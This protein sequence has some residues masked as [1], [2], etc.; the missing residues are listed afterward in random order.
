MKIKELYIENFGKLSKLKTSFSDGINSFVEDNGFG[1][2]TLSV[3]IKAMLYGFD[4]TRRHS[5]DEN[6]RKKYNPWQGGAFG[7]YLIFETNGTVYRVERTFGAKASDD[8]YNLYNLNTGRESEDFGES[9]GEELFGIDAE[10]FERT[11]FLS[12]KNL[13]GKNT[14]QTISAK[15]SNLVGTEGDIGGFDEAIKLLDERRKF[16]QKRGGAGEIQDVETEISELEDKIK[17]L[18]AKRSSTLRS[19]TEI[20]ALNEKISALRA[21]KGSIVEKERREK[22][23]KEK[24]GYEIQYREM[25]GALTVDEERERELLS[26]FS[27]KIPTNA[28]LALAADSASE[29][30]RLER[31]LSDIGENTELE[32]LKEFFAP[33][34]TEEECEKMKNAARRVGE[35]RAA[36]LSRPEDKIE[37]APFK[38]TPT[39]KEVE[40]RIASIETPA[41]KRSAVNSAVVLIGV[42][43]TLLGIL[44]GLLISIPL[45]SLSALGILLIFV[46]IM[47]TFSHNS[48]KFSTQSSKDTSEFIYE[49]FGERI[50]FESQ[51]SALYE[52]KS[53]L[54]RYETQKQSELLIKAERESLS[55]SILSLEREVREFCERFPAADGLT[56]EEKTDIISRKRRRFDMLLEY[57]SEKES[58]RSML[59]EK[60]KNHKERLESFLTLFPTRTDDPISEIRKNLA[61]YEVIRSSLARRRGDAER[62]ASSHGINPNGNFNAYTVFDNTNDFSKELS[63]LEEELLFCEREKARIE[64]DYSITMREIESTEELEERLLEKKEKIELFRD[65][66]S[67]ITKTKDMLAKSRDSMTSKYLDSTKRGFEKYLSLIDEAV[68]EFTIDT[69]FTIMKTDQGKSRQAE[70]YSRGTRDMHALAMRLSLVDALYG[71]N[72]PP[73]ILDDPFIAFDDIHVERASLVLKKLAREH[74]ILYF[75]CSKSR[76]IK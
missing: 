60:I 17:T 30:T 49:V 68:G 66:L 7:G 29:I 61:E 59:I 38:K 14:N 47:P 50:R 10:G 71:K 39:M 31:T 25:L 12:E 21:K 41:K 6:D 48:K 57:E 75:S 67:V 55:Q 27:A 23:E 11:V 1:K 52:I 54:L 42:L 37:Q 58:N 34:A 19:E 76:R 35:I 4:D 45:Y 44:A 72:S 32:S 63:A 43:I 13:S 64:T 33:G 26:F 40:D 70:A 15:L 65:N 16:Y 74:Q 56:L 3:F 46:G 24:R 53:K 22:L 36:L 51:I 18:Y 9:L 5:L 69:S 73:I 20:T 28:E 2:T 8:T 62:F